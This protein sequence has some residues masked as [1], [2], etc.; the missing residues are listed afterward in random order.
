MT[1]DRGVEAPEETIAR[2]ERCRVSWMDGHL[3]KPVD[4]A[5]LRR[6]VAELLGVR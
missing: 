2:L 3:S 5:E 4:L 6:V 1:D